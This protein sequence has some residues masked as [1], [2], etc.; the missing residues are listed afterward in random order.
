MGKMTKNQF[1][2]NEAAIQQPLKNKSLTV[3]MTVNPE[4][5]EEVIRFLN[6]FF[7]KYVSGLSF[8]I[9]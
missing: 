1:E 6:K 4:N 2:L 7:G 9:K 8:N 3:T 5:A